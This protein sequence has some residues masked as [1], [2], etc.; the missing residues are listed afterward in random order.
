MVSTLPPTSKFASPFRN[1]LVNDPNALITIGVIVTCMFHS[2][3]F[4]FHSK[5]EA[6]ILL[7][8]FFQFHSM[9]TRDSK[10]DDF[11]SSFFFFLL[12]SGLVF[13]PKL[14]WSECMSNITIIIIII[15]IIIIYS[16]RIF[17]ISV[18]WWSFTR[19]LVEACLFTCLEL[20]SVFWPFSIMLSF[21]WFPLTLSCQVLDSLS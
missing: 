15:I 16:L 17:R 12:L 10:V 5:V 3:F 2:F 7:C 6:L 20:F 13:W 18:R 4:Q 11:V 19:V 1:L 8:T 14:G 21:G 9:V